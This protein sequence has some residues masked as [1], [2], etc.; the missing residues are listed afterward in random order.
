MRCCESEM[1][2]LVKLGA[3]AASAPATRLSHLKREVLWNGNDCVGDV[4]V[5]VRHLTTDRFGAH[6]GLAA[7]V[8]KEGGGERHEYRLPVATLATEHIDVYVLNPGCLTNATVDFEVC[9][10]LT[11]ATV[12]VQPDT[13][14]LVH[15]IGVADMRGTGTVVLTEKSSGFHVR[16]CFFFEESKLTTHAR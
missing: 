13:C 14:Q 9:R 5:I 4:Y 2:L 15:T 10:G 6:V 16:L 1:Q 7:V 12:V 8:E 3:L 11:Y